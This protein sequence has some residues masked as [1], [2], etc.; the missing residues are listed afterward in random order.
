MSGAIGCQ[1]SFF[2]HIAQRTFGQRCVAATRPAQNKSWGNGLV[3]IGLHLL[4][5]IIISIGTS[6]RI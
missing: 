6:I 4:I 5:V 2:V 1:R 3:Q